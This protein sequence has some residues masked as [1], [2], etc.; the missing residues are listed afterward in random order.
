M[1]SCAGFRKRQVEGI[2]R[3]QRFTRK[4]KREWIDY[5]VVSHRH[6][7]CVPKSMRTRVMPYSY[8][9]YSCKN[10]PAQPLSPLRIFVSLEPIQLKLHAKLIGIALLSLRSE[11]L[12][13]SARCD[14]RGVCSACLAAALACLDRKYCSVASVKQV[15]PIIVILSSLRADFVGRL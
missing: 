3:L 15:I 10:Y 8:P 2:Y 9:P 1:F 14:A 13:N 7:R 5:R 6:L 11:G 4:V 12:L